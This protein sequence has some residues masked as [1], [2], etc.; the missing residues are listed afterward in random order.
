MHNEE[1]RSPCYAQQYM[2]RANETRPVL[3]HSLFFCMRCRR[4]VGTYASMEY[5]APQGMNFV[6]LRARTY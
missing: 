1:S 2:E 4:N 6:C 3:T 5:I